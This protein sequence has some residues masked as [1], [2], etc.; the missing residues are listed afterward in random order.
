VT[1]FADAEAV[2]RRDGDA[3]VFSAVVAEIGGAERSW[4]TYAGGRLAFDQPTSVTT[5][6]VFDLASLTKVLSTTTAALQLQRRGRLDLEAPVC[7]VLPAWRRED[8][9]GVTVRDL[10]EHCSGLPAH[11]EYFH[12]L[13][14]LDAYVRAIA[15]EP[16][17]YSPRSSAL[18]S[19]LGFI[20]L[21]AVIERLGDASLQ[22]QFD[23]WK[24][25]AQI[26]GP[27][28]YLPPA[29]WR[30][31]TA[32][33]GYDAWRGRLLQGEVH[34]QNAAALGGVAA[35]AGLFGTAAS[36]GAA[37]RWWLGQLG[38]PDGAGFARRS[39]VPGS[40]RALG[41]DT[42][43]P[44]SSCGRRMSA[45]AVGHTGFT[46]T[47]LWIDP[48]RGA[49]FVLLTNRVLASRDSDA[50]QRLRREFHDAACGD[51]P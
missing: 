14:G 20:T 9:K 37:A 4:W 22:H 35:H 18:Y 25:E 12:R 6:T 23:A 26:D 3:K 45:S 10:L 2:L 36:V 41:W 32:T 42:M 16:L 28:T 39:A 51:L 1:S 7:H 15:A 27:L 11:R 31:R 17:G 48:E 40:S 49:Y 21:G 38:T 47:S 19:D 30:P 44:T 33:T 5:A 8:R 13:I 34:D 46:G 29:E 43:L 24:A 50:I